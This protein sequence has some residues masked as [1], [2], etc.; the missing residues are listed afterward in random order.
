[1]DFRRP[2]G[3]HSCSIILMPYF[4]SPCLL[5]AVKQCFPPA[6]FPGLYLSLSNFAVRLK[7][8]RLDCPNA[9]LTMIDQ[10]I[11]FDK[12]KSKQAG[13]LLSST[14]LVSKDLAWAC[15]T[16][17]KPVVK[18]KSFSG[19]WSIGVA[20]KCSTAECAR[21]WPIGFE[22][23]PCCSL[24]FPQ[25]EKLPGL[26]TMRVLQRLR[27]CQ[28]KSARAKSWLATP[29]RAVVLLMQQKTQYSSASRSWKT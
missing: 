14:M 21:L 26:Q 11:I 27:P 28:S 18:A 29:S 16:L 13:E 7:S 3:L 6:G 9:R 1:M 8:S 25:T 12:L 19:V 5:A 17:A 24:K 23:V 22:R 15:C 4:K 2:I 20:G 10:T